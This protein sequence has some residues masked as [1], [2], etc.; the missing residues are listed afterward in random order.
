M[1]KEIASTQY[2]FFVLDDE[3]YA[4]KA[5]FVQEIVDFSTVTKVPKANPC[6]RGITNIR[7]DLIAVVD[8]KQRFKNERLEVQK[9]TSFIIIN[10]LN[11]R[12]NSIVPIA[13]MVDLVDE[14]EDISFDDI[15]KTPEFGS[16][17]DERF[18]E[19]IV[20]YGEEYIMVLD[21]EKVLDIEELSIN[22]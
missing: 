5:S 4:I 17:I 1:D 14:V 6:V 19:N 7:G 18:L 10:I 8:P 21:I 12:K 16:K 15:L 2:L 9:R 22:S 11:E 20:R 3:R 13:L